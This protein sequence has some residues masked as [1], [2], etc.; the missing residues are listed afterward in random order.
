MS[1]P[2]SFVRFGIDIGGNLSRKKVQIDRDLLIAQIQNQIPKQV[3]ARNLGIGRTTL[4][5]YLKCNPITAEEINNV[6]ASVEVLVQ[7]KN[8]AKE[9]ENG[10][11]ETNPATIEPEDNQEFLEKLMGRLDAPKD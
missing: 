2:N 7:K 3:I 4:Y 11:E 5:D 10:T 9:V 6:S 8:A 1:Y